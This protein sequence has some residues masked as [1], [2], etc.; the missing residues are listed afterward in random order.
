MTQF[1]QTLEFL[2][3]GGPVLMILAGMSVV[4]TALILIKVYQFYRLRLFGNH[5]LG[6]IVDKWV[7][8]RS[9]VSASLSG[10][11]HPAAVVLAFGI[12]ELNGTSDRSLE[13][14]REEVARVAAAQVHALTRY[15]RGLEVIAQTAPLLGLLGTIFGMITAFQVLEQAGS[16]ADPALL[17]GGIWEALLT[18]AAGLSVAIP[19]AAAHHWLQSVV[20]RATRDVED[21]ATRMLT[22]PTSKTGETEPSRAA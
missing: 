22:A 18:T 21:L 20:D 14:I 16:R 4:M 2:S 5:R 7:T 12:K 13:Q 17:A 3:A 1:E 19:A 6:D 11:S 10:N 9:D 15:L 8:S